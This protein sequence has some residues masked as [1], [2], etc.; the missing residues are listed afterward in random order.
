VSKDFEVDGFEIYNCRYRNFRED[1]RKALINFL[2]FGIVDWHVGEYMSDVWTVFHDGNSGNIEKTTC[3]EILGM[4]NFT[5][6]NSR[7]QI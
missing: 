3:K 7:N 1:D 5:G 4:D 2:I 6:R